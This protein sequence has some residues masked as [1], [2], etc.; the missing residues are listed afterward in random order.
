MPTKRSGNHPV[1]RLNL[2]STFKVFGIF[3]LISPLC[4]RGL[5]LHIKKAVQLQVTSGAGVKVSRED[6]ITFPI[7][8]MGFLLL[9]PR[10]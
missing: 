3:S 5:S 1:H 8:F 7:T 10:L 9:F 4:G 6:T 2:K